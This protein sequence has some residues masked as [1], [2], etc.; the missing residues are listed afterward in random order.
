MRVI[1]ARCSLSALKKIKC[2]L[3]CGPISK[4]KQKKKKGR[5]KSKE[6]AQLRIWQAHRL[7]PGRKAEPG[8]GKDV[9]KDFEVR[10]V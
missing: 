8:L 10:K 4:T 5:R 2:A 9:I 7:L 1:R 3:Y 6:K